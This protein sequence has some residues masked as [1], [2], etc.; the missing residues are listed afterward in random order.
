[1]AFRTGWNSL[2]ELRD[3]AFYP[4]SDQ[5]A[6]DRAVIETDGNLKKAGEHLHALFLVAN[7]PSEQQGIVRAAHGACIDEDRTSTSSRSQNGHQIKLIDCM[8]SATTLRRMSN[9]NSHPFTTN[10]HSANLRRNSVEMEKRRLRESYEEFL[11]T[12]KRE[13]GPRSAHM[14]AL[15]MVHKGE[16][17]GRTVSDTIIALEGLLP[18]YWATE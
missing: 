1:M 3:I 7:R 14:F 12:G 13:P 6:F 9:A 2:E 4:G 8:R 11:R 5:A 17:S 16:L 18:P 15:A 10:G